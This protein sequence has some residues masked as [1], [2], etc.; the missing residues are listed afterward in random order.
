MQRT[1][2]AVLVIALLAPLGCGGGSGA[3]PAA[4]PPQGVEYVTLEPKPIEQTTEYIG[5]V[6]SRSSTTIQP[7]AE[8]V[9]RSIAVRSGDR[10][11]A[12]ALLLEIDDRQQA[13]EAAS[14][15][16]LRAGREADVQYARQQAERQQKL[17]AAGAVS[18]QEAQQAQ[19]ALETAE[20]QLRAAEQQLR[21]ARVELGY[22]RVTA[23][24]A[25]VVGDIPVRV[26]DRVTHATPLTT[27]DSGAAFELYLFVPVQQASQLKTGLVVK[28]VGDDGRDLSETTIDFVSPQV[29]EKTQGLLV[30]APLSSGL[31]LRPEQFVRA[32]VVWREEPG[33]TVPVVAVSRVGGQFFAFVVSDE[34]GHSVARQRALHLGPI[35]G[36]DYL[37]VDGLERGERLI[38]SGVQKVGDGAAVT[39][40]PQAAPQ[41]G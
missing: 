3:A 14:F 6:K 16:S 18:E 13:A 41:P 22:Y 8:G 26:G 37:L 10:V 25:G 33:L 29:D 15:E 36:N 11:R 17:L 5:T 21:A 34:G 12:G 2:V 7:Q 38:V 23:P 31:G 9:I 28:L 27:I 1:A 19:A 40:R 35:I 32:V 39:A 24:T 30:K 4:P 20:A